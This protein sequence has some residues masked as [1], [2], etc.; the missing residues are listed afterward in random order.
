MKLMIYEALKVSDQHK[1]ERKVAF[2]LSLDIDHYGLVLT[3]NQ[4]LNNM[5]SGEQCLIK[6]LLCTNYFLTAFPWV[7][8]FDTHIIIT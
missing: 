6:E 5:M 1:D 2:S 7:Y 4:S 8:Q 3:C